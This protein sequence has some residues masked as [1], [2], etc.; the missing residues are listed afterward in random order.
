VKRRLLRWLACPA[1]HGSLDVAT[2]RSDTGAEIDE[3]QL[4]CAACRT[5]YPITRGIPRLLPPTVTREGAETAERFGYEWTRFAEIRPEYETQFR[6]WIAPVS[7]EAFKGRIVVDGGCGKGRHLR[8]AAAFGAQEVIGMDLGPAA[9]VAARN[10][11]DLEN[12]HVIQAD[13]THPPLVRGGID[14]IYSIGVLHHLGEPAA[15][16]Q[17]LAPLL[18]PGGMLVAWL[19]AREG[20]GWVL[21]L[22]DPV[23][24]ITRRLPLPLVSGLARVLTIPLWVAIRLL[25]APARRHAWL[26]ALL[27]YQGYLSDLVPFPFRE[28]HSIAFDQLLAP[29]AHYMPREHVERCFADAAVELQSLRWHHENSW[30]AWGIAAAPRILKDDA[31]G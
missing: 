25:Y 16:F 31:P 5:R 28:V 30:A 22:V 9:E 8:L 24:R 6:G 4:A 12:V 20:N 23:R 19:Y 1:C 18:R 14:L 7:P 2:I 3:G 26:R 13:L 10:A 15:G 11:R 17:A 29:V 21:A 27:P